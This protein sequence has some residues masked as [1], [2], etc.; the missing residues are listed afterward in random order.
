MKSLVVNATEN[1]ALLGRYYK[2]VTCS[3]MCDVEGE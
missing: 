3:E 2:G 1:A